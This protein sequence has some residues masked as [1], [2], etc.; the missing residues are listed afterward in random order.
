MYI[1]RFVKYVILLWQILRKYPK[2]N[3]DIISWPRTILKTTFFG[4]IM[5]IFVL[6]GNIYCVYNEPVCVF[7]ASYF[8]KGEYIQYYQF[9]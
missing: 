2:M 3:Y 1:L 9:H 8:M 5:A 7:L 6:V 4:T